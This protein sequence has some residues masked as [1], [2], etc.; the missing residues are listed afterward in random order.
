MCRNTGTVWAPQRVLPSQRS[1]GC[2]EGR[3]GKDVGLQLT[4]SVCLVLP[5]SRLTSCL[6]RAAGIWGRDRLREVWGRSARR[7]VSHGTLENRCGRREQT[8]EQ[9]DG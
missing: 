1:A 4:P 7:C 8:D 6:V 9:E 5:R 3:E 2:R